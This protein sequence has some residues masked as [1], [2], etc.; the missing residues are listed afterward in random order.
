[1]SEEQVMRRKCDY[2]GET[3]E[4]DNKPISPADGVRVAGWVILVRV[5]LVKGQSQAVQKHA[6]KDSCAINIISL[7]MLDLPQEVKD[8]LAEEKRLA[9]ELQKKLKD[10][11]GGLSIAELGAETPSDAA[12][13]TPAGEA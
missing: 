1:M 7:G 13:L 12:L 8:M 10:K 6:C 5:F 9:D 3:Q 4:F 2:C 11:F